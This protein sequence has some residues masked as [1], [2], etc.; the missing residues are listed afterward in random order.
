MIT[1]KK[2]KQIENEEGALKKLP[3][4]TRLRIKVN[5][6]YAILVLTIWLYTNELS[7]KKSKLGRTVKHKSVCLYHL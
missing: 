4:F 3:M 2:I 5:E 6:G 7:I 1:I